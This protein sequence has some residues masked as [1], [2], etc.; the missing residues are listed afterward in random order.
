MAKLLC[1]IKIWHQSNHG[2]GAQWAAQVVQALGARNV[3]STT[4]MLI[5][6]SVR[7][8]GAFSRP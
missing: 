8:R 6:V 3:I 2:N 4:N 1:S 5:L 7:G